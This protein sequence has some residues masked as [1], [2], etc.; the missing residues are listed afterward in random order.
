[1]NWLRRI[2]IEFW[3]MAIVAAI[4]G[5]LG[6]FGTYLEDD[7]MGR[8]WRWWMHLMGAYVLVR[9]SILLW[10]SIAD[11]TALPKRMLVYSGVFLSSFPLAMLWSWSAGA[12]FHGLDGFGGILPF[13]MLSAIGVLGVAIW[14]RAVDLHLAAALAR[15]DRPVALA[16]EAAPVARAVPGNIST[17]D[18][19][20]EP[21]LLRRL[22][23][24]FHGPVIALQSEDHY[25]RVHG[26]RGSELV[27]MR[28]RDA[29]SEM[30]DC[31]GEQVHRSWW[32]ARGAIASVE[33]DGRNRTVTL[34]NGAKAPV[35]RDSVSRLERK[36][37]FAENDAR[38]T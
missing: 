7:F 17:P 33:A 27:F 24:G 6:P 4:I 15:K 9:P 38:L 28:L 18:E 8:V 29:I 30:D 2:L 20:A 34:L 21:R 13:A 1:M 19:K 10:T 5:F 11:A 35:A 26:V 23:P 12:F 32:M 25:V 16:P 3:A 14:A 31:P 36:Q 37:F 22:S